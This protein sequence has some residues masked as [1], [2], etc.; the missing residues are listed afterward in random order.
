MEK[1]TYAERSLLRSLIIRFPQTVGNSTV[2]F[3]AR[4]NYQNLNLYRSLERKGKLVITES[5]NVTTENML[6]GMTA[7]TF[8][9][10]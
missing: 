1:L 3:N 10:S 7:I 8:N 5:R 9:F 2:V 4:K 6:Y